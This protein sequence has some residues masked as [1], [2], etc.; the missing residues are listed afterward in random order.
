MLIKSLV[1]VKHRERSVRLSF[2]R[3]SAYFW[4]LQIVW[5]PSIVLSDA[6]WNWCVWRIKLC[7]WKHFSI[8]SFLACLSNSKYPRNL[9][10]TECFKNE[11]FVLWG[12]FLALGSLSGVAGKLCPENLDGDFGENWMTQRPAKLSRASWAASWFFNSGTQSSQSY[13]KRSCFV[14]SGNVAMSC[15]SHDCSYCG[16]LDYR[17]LYHFHA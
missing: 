10:S 12:V 13:L 15:A 17:K 7:L 16:A 5:G 4:R 1:F 8:G 11:W 14:S 2:F 6:R 9:I 3:C